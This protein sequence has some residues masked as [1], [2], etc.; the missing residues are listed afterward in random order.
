MEPALG[1]TL[2]WLLFG[3]AHVGLA[4]RRIRAG[5]VARLGEGGF[6]ALFSLVAASAFALLV[7]YYAAHR[8]EGAPGFA[9]GEAAAPRSVLVA[10][11]MVGIV[12]SAGSLAAY[13]R[14]PMAL[15]AE[16]APS[17]RG[18]E[19]ITRH[20]FFSG[21]A[22]WALAHAL[23]ATRLVGTAIFG[24]LALLTLIGAWHQDRKLLRRR[25]QPYADYLAVTSALPF[26]AVLA[27]RQRIVWRELPW[28]AFATGFAVSFALRAVHGS[29]LSHGGAWVT[30]SVVGGAAILSFESWRRA[31]L[32]VRAPKASSKSLSLG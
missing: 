7:R 18:I 6:L 25:G 19:R 28:S 20:S 10:T 17:P 21:V 30:G 2:L 27:G 1:V 9:L 14:S 26:A 11:I 29:I 13:P 32:V 24:E 22:L 4:T 15:F 31:R 16:S 3:G 12:L 8:F 23:L 5:L